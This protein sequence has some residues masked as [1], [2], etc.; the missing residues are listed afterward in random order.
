MV[1]RFSSSFCLFVCFALW[2]QVYIHEGSCFMGT[3]S[4]VFLLVKSYVYVH[5]CLLLMMD[6]GVSL[7]DWL[8]RF[9]DDKNMWEL[10]L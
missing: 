7:L 2:L 1:I 3:Q 6:Y 8:A 10:G 5:S 4:L 9:G